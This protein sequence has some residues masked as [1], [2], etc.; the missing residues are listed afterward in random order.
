ME[1]AV[2]SSLFTFLSLLLQ[3]PETIIMIIIVYRGERK[4]EGRR[5][6]T[7]IDW[8][9]ESRFGQSLPKIGE[10]EG[11]GASLRQA[12]DTLYP[13]LL[14]F[15]STLTLEAFFLM[16][17]LFLLLFCGRLIHWPKRVAATLIDQT[18][19]GQANRIRFVE[20]LWFFVR[21]QIS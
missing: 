14:S 18:G 10:R 17:F 2:A 15:C 21:Q 9:I 6:K 13:S 12:I 5:K 20:P 8:T 11:R 7:E 19:E 16:L 3:Q 4:R 1:A